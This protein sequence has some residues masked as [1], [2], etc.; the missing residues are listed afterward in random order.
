MRSLG[1]FVLAVL[2]AC[3]AER[4]TRDDAEG[5]PA[6]AISR[7]RDEDAVRPAG[8][9]SFA[10]DA[11]EVRYVDTHDHFAH[12]ATVPGKTSAPYFKRRGASRE[13]ALTFDCA[14]VP[15]DA[16]LAVLD[17]LRE[18]GVK[19]TFFVAG[20]FVVAAGSRGGPNE[21]TARVVR[22]IVADGHEV[23]NHTTTHPHLSAAV[24]WEGELS[25]LRGA[26]DAS[27]ARVFSSG[28]AGSAPPNATMTWMW[29]APFGEYDD[30]S[31]RAAA[32]AGYRAHVGWHVDVHD[33]LGFPT[34]RAAPA[35]PTCLDAAKETALVT[36][37]VRKNPGEDVIVVLAHLGAPYGFG[38]DPRG[39]RALVASMRAE[40][41][42]FAKISDV[43]VP[44]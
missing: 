11:G 19:S 18:T 20:P 5:E 12:A 42:V 33:A 13:I 28:D 22:R 1:S 37:F 21:A 14:W 8:R 3:S 4:P 40:G 9:G 24:R 6:R 25:R 39:I 16:G 10:T 41:L 7:E 43:L 29:R 32:A 27:V 35:D 44:P 36:S 38:A 30:R 26:W 17:A 34:C 15:E 31:L 2:V 23:G